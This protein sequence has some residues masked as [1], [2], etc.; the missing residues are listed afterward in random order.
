MAVQKNWQMK[1]TWC[2]GI[3]K[4]IICCFSIWLNS[5]VDFS[6]KNILQNVHN[7]GC[8]EWSCSS[9]PRQIQCSAISGGT[10]HGSTSVNRFWGPRT[11]HR[12]FGFIYTSTWHTSRDFPVKTTFTMETTHTFDTICSV[13]CT[14]CRVPQQKYTFVRIHYQKWVPFQTCL[15]WCSWFQTN[16]GQVQMTVLATDLQKMTAQHLQWIQ[17]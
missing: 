15:V 5:S 10:W 11:R 1:Q 6:L 14:E 13:V 3:Q 8:L 12:S 7:E 2:P 4:T 17:K 16:W 9:A